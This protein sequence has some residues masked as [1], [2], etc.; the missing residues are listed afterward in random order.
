MTS[1]VVPALVL[2]L[3][4][5]SELAWGHWLALGSGKRLALELVLGSALE[6]AQGLA[7]EWALAWE[8]RLA[9]VLVPGLARAWEHQWEQRLALAW[10]RRLERAWGHRLE[11]TH[12]SDQAGKHADHMVAS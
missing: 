6:L 4:P 8:H 9:L 10:E 3:E 12:N 5:E 2:V 1:S 11:P 7:Q